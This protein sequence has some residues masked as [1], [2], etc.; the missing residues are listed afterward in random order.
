MNKRVHRLV[1]DRKR[2]MRVPA[3]EHVRSSGKAA[4]GQTR[5]GRHASASQAMSFAMGTLTVGALGMSLGGWGVAEARSIGDVVPRSATTWVNRT[6]PDA[7]KT[8][9]YSANLP[10]RSVLTAGKDKGNFS[11][12]Y[13]T[14]GLSDDNNRLVIDQAD[15][16]VQ[17]NWDSFNVGRGYAVRFNQ[18]DS[19]STAYN[20]I[21]DNSPS[22]ILGKISANGEVILENTNGIIFGPTARVETQRFVATALAISQDALTKGIRNLNTAGGDQAQVSRALAF[23]TDSTDKINSSIV[24]ERGAEIRA[25]AGGD[26]M[27]FAPK[28]YNEGRIET[29]KGQTIL[30][31]GQKVYLMASTDL[32][33]RG[34]MVAVD[35]FKAAPGQ[36]LPA[37]TNTVEQAAKGTYYVDGKGDTVE[38]APGASLSGLTARINEVVAEKGTINLVGMSI[39]QNG[40]LT[41]T[42]AVKGEN[43]AIFLHAGSSARTANIGGDG[44]LSQDLG[45]VE[46]G[47]GSVT[48]VKPDDSAATQ[49]SNDVFY[50]SN[51]EVLGK[52]IR[53]RSGATVSAQSG[54]ISL[55]GMASTVGSG[56]GANGLAIDATNQVTPDDSH[57]LVESGAVL[58]VSGV[59]GVKVSGAR[60]QMQTRLFKIELADAPVQRDG[61]IYRQTLSFDARDAIGIGNVSG[62]YSLI[63]RTAQE[64][65]TT[66]GALRI[67]GMGAV[68]VQDGAKLNLSGGSVVFDAATIQ[69]SLLRQGDRLVTLDNASADLHYDA[70]LAT[71]VRRS[72]G[73]YVQGYDAGSASIA[74][75]VKTVVGLSGVDGSVVVGPL[76]RT[77][78]LAGNTSRTDASVVK[79]GYS[80]LILK[81]PAALATKPYLEGQLRPLQAALTI[82]KQLEV[83]Q[84]FNFAKTIE[85]TPGA[86]S[87]FTAVP[88]MGTPE[89]AA[90]FANLSDKTT[91]S[92]DA[93]SAARLGSLTLRADKVTVLDG[94]RILLGTAGWS[95]VDA[96]TDGVRN[97]L[98]IASDQDV[99]FGGQVIAEGGRVVV[100]GSEIT[101]GKDAKVDV[102]GRLLDERNVSAAQGD[103]LTVDGGTVTLNAAHAMT[104]SKGSVVNV[105]AG[106]WRD[107][108][109]T[110]KKGSAGALNLNYN[111]SILSA[112]SALTLGGQMLGYGFSSGGTFNLSGSYRLMLGA[113]QAATGTDVNLDLQAIASQG[114]NTI[115][116]TATG[117]VLVKSE[118]G[119]IAPVLSNYRLA[120][121]RGNVGSNPL[122][123]VTTLSD[124]LRSALNL[125]LSATDQPVSL[126]AADGKFLPGGS[127]K[128][129]AGA[130][131]DVGV[132]GSI[133]LNA[134]QSVELDGTLVARGGSATLAITGERGSADANSETTRD[135]AGYVPDQVVRLGAQSKIDVSGIAKTVAAANGRVTGAVLAGGTVRL[136]DTGDQRA[137]RGRVV[138]EVGSQ[139]D[140]SGAQG[141]IS[142]GREAS[143]S[144]VFAGAGSLSVRSTD[145]FLMEGSVQARRP[146]ASVAGGS[147]SASVSREGASDDTQPT[148]NRYTATQ[149]AIELTATDGQLAAYRGNADTGVGALSAS[150]LNN[151]GFD[152]VT[153]RADDRVVLRSSA[154]EGD[155]PKASANL[156]A[157][158]G[159]GYRSVIID[160]QALEARG[161]DHQ[162]LAQ[163]V[164]LGARTVLPTKNATSVAAPLATTGDAT[165]QVH[166]G[167]I[168]AFG[169]SALQGLKQTS[170]SATLGTDGQSLNRQNGEIRFIGRSYLNSKTLNGQLNFAGALTLNSG[171]VYAS[172]LSDFTVKGLAGSSTLTLNPPAEAMASTSG[173]PLSAL[174]HLSLQAQD[175]TVNGT[176]RQPFGRID[177][178]PDG[179][180]TLGAASELSVSGQGIQVPVGNTINQRDWVYAITGSQDGTVDPTADTTRVLSSLPVDKAI[181]LNGAKLSISPTSKL[182]ASAG[183]D[184]VASE[185]VAGVGG[186]TDMTTRKNVYVVLPSYSYEFSPY[187]TDIRA[188]MQAVGTS[189]AEGGQIV[190]TSANGVLQP[191][192]YTLLPARYANLPGAVMVSA[193]T[194]STGT[195]SPGQAALVNGI[196][197]D[198]G[199]VVVSGYMTAA[200]SSINGGNDTRLALVLEPQST[201]GK[202]S[203]IASVSINALLESQS[204]GATRRPGEGGRVTLSSANAFNWSANYRLNANEGFGGGQLDLGMKDIQLVDE[205]PPGA[206]PDGSVSA[207]ALAATGAASI[208]LGGTR[209]SDGQG[210]TTVN[211]VADTLSVKANV[212]VPGE[213]IL[214][215]KQTLSVDAGVQVVAGAGSGSTASRPVTFSGD[216]AALVVSN[217]V[218]TDV[219]R[220]GTT[221]AG[222]ASLV[223]GD[224]VVLAGDAVQLDSSNVVVRQGKLNLKTASLGVGSRRVA[225]GNG[226]AEAGVFQMSEASTDAF[227]RLQIRGYDSVTLQGNLQ[228]GAARDSRSQ[229]LRELVLDTAN[230]RGVAS[231][232][233]VT[234][235]AAVLRAEHVT[236]RNTGDGVTDGTVT[237]S[238]GLTVIATP[239]VA[240]RTAEGVTLGPG[241]Q[242]LA[243]N[244][245][246]LAT[247]GDIVA[248]S[249]A[250]KATSLSSQSSLL[251]NAARVTAGTAAQATIDSD[252][253][254]KVVAIS[255]SKADDPQALVAAS[256]TLNDRVGAGASLTLSGQRVVQAG[257]VDV[258]SG[259]IQVV[260]RGSQDSRDTVVF[261]TGSVTKAAG[262]TASAGTWSANANGG[263]I[264]A[265]AQQG[266]LL[267]RGT[268][269]VSAPKSTATGV[270]SGVAGSIALKAAGQGNAAQPGM[271]VLSSG[272]QLLG[273]AEKD[274]Q[275]GRVSVDAGRLIREEDRNLSVSQLAM[276][277]QGLD[278]L[279][280]MVNDGGNR[281]ELNVR[282]HQGDLSLSQALKSA[283]VI[284]SADNGSLTLHE[285]AKIDATA[286]RGGVVQLAASGDVTMERGASIDASSSAAGANGGDVLLSSTHGQIDLQTGAAVNAAGSST[287]LGRIVLRAEVT[288][289]GGVK[290]TQPGATLTAGDVS[291]EAVKRFT[292]SGDVVIAST[293]AIPVGSS[294]DVVSYVS[295]ITTDNVNAI[296]SGLGWSIDDATHHVR[297]GI[298]IQTDGDFTLNKDW[299]LASL[300]AA[301]EP[302][303]LTVR[304]GGNLTLNGHLS[305]GFASAAPTTGTTPV[306]LLSGDGASMRLIAG[307]D[308]QAA[309]LMATNSAG[310]GSLTVAGGKVVRTTS[311]SI[312]LAAAKDI[313]LQ[314]DAKTGLLAS[315]YVAGKTSANPV[316]ASTAQRS[317]WQTFTRAGG[318]LE[319]TAGQDI[320]S[321]LPMQ[322]FGNWLLHTSGATASAVAW[323]TSFDAFHQGFGSMGGGNL[324]IDA[325][326]DVQNIG[327]VAPTSARTVTDSTTKANTQVVE[328]GGDVLV[329]AG[330][331]IHGGIYLIGR[332]QGSIEAGGRI[333]QGVREGSDAAV[334]DG[335]GLV[336]GVMDG[337]WSVRANGD[338]N[339]ATVI[340]PTPVTSVTTAGANQ[341][342][343]ASQAGRYFTYTANSALSIASTYGEIGWRAVGG[344]SSGAADALIALGQ[345]SSVKAENLVIGQT[346]VDSDFMVWLTAM[347]PPTVS[348]AAFTGDVVLDRQMPLALYPSAQGN[349]TVYAG[350]QLKLGSSTA[351]AGVVS[352][353]PNSLVLVDADL[354]SLS[355]TTAKPVANGSAAALK[356]QLEARY[357]ENASSVQA[358]LSKTLHANDAVPVRIHAGS[359]IIF[360]GG[361]TLD[362]SKQADVSA[363]GKIDSPDIRTTHFRSTDIT[364]VTAGQ[365]ILGLNAAT[366]GGVA[367]VIQVSGPGELQVEAG[368]NLDL[369]TSA[370]IETVGNLYNTALGSESASIRVAAGATQSVN[371]TAFEADFLSKDAQARNALIAYVA[372]ALAL[373]AKS[374][375]YEQ[376]LTN[377]AMLTPAHQTAFAKAVARDRFV[378]QFITP[379]ALS[380]GTDPVWAFVAARQGQSVTD[381]NSTAYQT[382]LDAKGALISYVRSERKLSG[383]LSYDD[384]LAAY[385]GFDDTR[386][387]GLLDKRPEISPV[388][389]AAFLAVGTE[390]NYA[391]LW[392]A[393]VAVAA[394][395]LRPGQSAASS[396]DYNSA[397]FA[398]YQDDVLM[399]EYKRLGMITTT[400][401]DS[402]NPAFTAKRA[403]VRDVFWS[404]MRDV[405]ELSGLRQTFT[406]VGDINMAGSKV[407]TQGTGNA[408]SG[409]ID[410][411][412]PGGKVIVGYSASSAH[413]RDP[414]IARRRGLITEGGSIRSYSLSDFQ[415]NSQKTVVAGDGDILIYSDGSNIDSGRGSNTDV[416]TVVP[417]RVRTASGE[418]VAFTPPPVSASGIR[419]VGEGSI[420]LLTPPPGEV[421]AL[422]AFI[423]GSKL[424][425]PGPVLGADNLQGSVKGQAAPPPVA[426]AAPVNTGLGVESAAGEAQT[427]AAKARERPRDASSVLTVDVLGAGD[428]DVALPP[429]AAGKPQVDEG[430]EADAK[431][432]RK[433]LAQ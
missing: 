355:G 368:R 429:P 42:T 95:G 326:R 130:R 152:R 143:T 340:N 307:A 272:A 187:D 354:A 135:G 48:Q 231:S 28:V 161:G 344:K 213:L 390:L 194:L 19:K 397:L 247:T 232:P 17:I 207:K 246:E 308:V 329:R 271:V 116:L 388:A 16:S 106:A 416:A 92:A 349:L 136:N 219:R 274:S 337:K 182:D 150:M 96:K 357:L 269:D 34:L 24:V 321:D 37:G 376:A 276:A 205:V 300:R 289:A 35:A 263:S 284:M 93:I 317:K 211:T 81:R 254:L 197:R 248:R 258:A 427:E 428:A 380:N 216:G 303:T 78:M 77:S 387:A 165:L 185:F 215:A 352:D 398:Q 2:G 341:R 154:G 49:T 293:A 171:V 189:F 277:T 70:L 30:A 278:R 310:N 415:I 127:V 134:G 115:G 412:S 54:D 124:G 29:P 382:Y 169:Y 348:L 203:E 6:V 262:W 265:E 47:A 237:G 168:E 118:G 190:V 178:T 334:V 148:A 229:A 212:A 369:R 9:P 430:K 225:V 195:S 14:E 167:L 108:N 201:F 125:T 149:R 76:Q 241:A 330:G 114:F 409:G 53:V 69:T 283:R 422:D 244:R 25:L 99:Y 181:K 236:L 260:G 286:E 282:V 259:A 346:S 147:F 5:A 238:T 304:A 4:G 292:T 361:S 91:L 288:D 56:G 39:R 287:D 290:V 306:A 43:G 71:T 402:S 224:G 40:V 155:L 158:V 411:F 350:G 62:A 162:I 375:S 188:S 120:L 163:Y 393:R 364:R 250:G 396:T 105:S 139:I 164:S 176:V 198:D 251:L 51:I 324:R 423:Q 425:V 100:S 200:G 312:E 184:I 126:S 374:L 107:T 129:E 299:N 389:V 145:G 137:V 228:I 301:G 433:P 370:G 36:T 315:V 67:E 320:K 426:V 418:V 253:D 157:N 431:R 362:L 319:A 104:L 199:S 86:S 64:L 223:L 61:A 159:G 323:G 405:A 235:E 90:Y 3:A 414:E 123:N 102:S 160:T 202:K 347:A 196:V 193:T 291:V 217:K 26:V 327:A 65:S 103:A 206:G 58:D 113:T 214:A 342:V 220:V 63:G 407:Q 328:N 280:K 345:A 204:D 316:G 11:L 74:G 245:A 117:G 146:D 332:G 275:S 314:A 186:S 424:F 210:G 366:T 180:L 110:V 392:E 144:T 417:T 109:G 55:L 209:E 325:G 172:T 383:V 119:A 331:D 10:F 45:D 378:Q 240:D 192:R 191:G 270:E 268:L 166:A 222:T 66:G 385:R 365:D 50:R 31:A 400:V 183:G 351:I 358:A 208:L 73:S 98:T 177:I 266:D 94:S 87:A 79:T 153:L 261:E 33:Q 174:A 80:S 41:A 132:G 133:R 339:V 131:L 142:L 267:V 101:L 408:G 175:I 7:A 309:H 302:I 256:R 8:S 373:D 399:S 57:V 12:T 322:M 83:G 32:I 285:G 38:V 59:R 122:V 89:Y 311:G 170:L 335:M 403:A 363:G 27:L 128:V 156:I 21:W 233:T 336:L 360:G 395:A 242:R 23:G 318:R 52:D 384:A 221:A 377:F 343:T 249:E 151:A 410:L 359:D 60:N 227:S 356:A 296:K 391:K 371:L 15:R 273:Q 338:V 138:T 226:P 140:I 1:F 297:T 112:P 230:L 85:V 353:A 46:L 218:A 386:K 72:V 264:R 298:E 20:K 88:E 97:S 421:R 44:I 381:T 367:G 413:D 234:N 419:Q 243:F 257:T 82:G 401:A 22:V 75:A 239:A 372:A 84:G 404:M 179:S 406:S 279:A 305:D 141:A 379:A 432:K 295:G 333:D 281:R 255:A 394:S 173:T 18:P 111:T 121:G 420:L 13:T 313:L 252:A 294:G 68:V